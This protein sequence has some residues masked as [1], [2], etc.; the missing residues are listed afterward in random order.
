MLEGQLKNVD[1]IDFKRKVGKRR[2]ERVA[3]IFSNQSN[4]SASVY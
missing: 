4:L 1:V 3:N 2:L